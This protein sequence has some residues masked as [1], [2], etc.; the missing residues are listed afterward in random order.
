MVADV[1]HKQDLK[2]LKNIPEMDRQRGVTSRRSSAQ[3]VSKL[4]PFWRECANVADLDREHSAGG[5]AVVT[6]RMVSKK[7]PGLVVSC[8]APSCASAFQNSTFCNSA[9]NP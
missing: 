8:V 5:D 2:K 7:P 9:L 3:F 1:S 4:N 6:F